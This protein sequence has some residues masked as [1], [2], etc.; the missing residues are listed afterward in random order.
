MIKWQ[1][2]F[3]KLATLL[4]PAFV[5]KFIT[6]TNLFN[7][8][9]IL[10]SL[11]SSLDPNGYFSKSNPDNGGFT[12]ESHSEFQIFQRRVQNHDDS[13]ETGNDPQHPIRR[14]R[15]TRLLYLKKIVNVTVAF[16]LFQSYDL[17]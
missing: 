9:I 1:I 6:L 13:S 17:E 12:S 14:Y 5:F 10:T 2:T 8:E 7:E 4:F 15:L 11:V 16:R 3:L